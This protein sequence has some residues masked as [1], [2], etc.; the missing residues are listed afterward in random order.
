MIQAGKQ[1][2]VVPDEAVACKAPGGAFARRADLDIRV[3][4]DYG[5]AGVL[6]LLEEWTSAEGVSYAFEQRSEP[7]ANTVLDPA[8]P[9]WAAV[10]ETL[11][12]MYS[13]CTR[14]QLLRGLA[15]DVAIFPGASGAS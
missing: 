13:C 9:W 4:E 3:A 1:V 2:N 15:Y 8:D 12:S 14:S 10:S 5:V 11:R 7:T 6:A